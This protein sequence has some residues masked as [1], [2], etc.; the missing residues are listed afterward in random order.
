MQSYSES[1]KRTLV[2]GRGTSDNR[3]VKGTEIRIYCV[4][5]PI[6]DIWSSE[7]RNVSTPPP[8]PPESGEF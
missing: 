4:E 5:L 3:S 7:I 2:T 8:F 6:P 1:L